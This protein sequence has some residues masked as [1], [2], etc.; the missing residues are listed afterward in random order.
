[1]R[2]R[3]GR[4]APR[5]HGGRAPLR[6]APLGLRP[7]GRGGAAGAGH[8]PLPGAGRAAL[9]GD[10]L[11]RRAARV[12]ADRGVHGRRAAGRMRAH[13][14]VV[15]GI[16]LH[17][18]EAGRGPAL[19]MLHGLTATHVNWEHTMA[20]FSSRFR[21]IAPDLPGHGHSEKP[22]APYTIDFFAGMMRSLGR[23]LGIDEAVVLGN[24][25]GGQIALQMAL[26]Y[27]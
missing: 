26:D 1:G 6:G 13:D 14:L 5:Q 25:L 9:D 8:V 27:P 11:R 7:R 21:V 2:A 16:R 19:L 24:S 10:G 17:V 3:G 20:A 23:E 15:D 18:T 22:D 4:A 12:A